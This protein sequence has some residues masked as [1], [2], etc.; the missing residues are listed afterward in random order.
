VVGK[1]FK[2]KAFLAT[3]GDEA[4][5]P[6]APPS[7]NNLVEV[8]NRPKRVRKIRD[9]NPPAYNALECNVAGGNMAGDDTAGGEGFL[10]GDRRVW[11]PS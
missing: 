11:L 10:A 3:E 8:K 7:F 6:L 1:L 4:P 9:F 2:P 5:G